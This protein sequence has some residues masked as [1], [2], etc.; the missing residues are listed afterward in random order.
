MRCLPG[1]AASYVSSDRTCNEERQTE[2]PIEVLDVIESMSLPPHRLELKFGSS[3]MVLQNIDSAANIFNGTR[4]IVSSLGANAIKATIVTGPNKG[5]MTS[6][7]ETVYI[8]DIDNV[9]NDF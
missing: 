2:M 3:I 7:L 5:D 1:R 9:H 4:L 6:K 8:Y